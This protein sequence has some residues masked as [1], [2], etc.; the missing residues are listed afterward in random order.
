M[1]DIVLYVVDIDFGKVFVYYIMVECLYFDIYFESF[2]SGML[3]VFF[4]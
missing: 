3:R 4:L 2:G 1:F